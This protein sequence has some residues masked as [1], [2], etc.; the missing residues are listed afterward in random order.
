MSQ[1]TKSFYFSI[2]PTLV[3]KLFS[4]LNDIFGSFSI[5]EFQ[6]GSFSSLYFFHKTLFFKYG[7][8]SFFMSLIILNMIYHF[9]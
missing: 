5:V 4:F 2:S 7:F 8:C 1:F 3:S 9:I 6:F